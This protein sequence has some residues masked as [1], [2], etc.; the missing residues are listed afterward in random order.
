MREIEKDAGERW[1]HLKDA[2]DERAT[3]A[4]DIDDASERREVVGSGDGDGV[5]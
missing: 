2:R 4:A 5:Y 3:A 1:V